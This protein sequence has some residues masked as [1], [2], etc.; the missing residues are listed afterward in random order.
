MT[1]SS[2]DLQISSL[3]LALV[4]VLGIGARA[5]Y[6]Y[7]PFDYR[8]INNWRQSDYL[9]ITRNFHR[10]GMNIFYPRVD[11]RGDTPGYVEMELPVLP[12]LGAW[13]YHFCGPHVQLLRALAATFD[14]GSLILFC[15]LA[16]DLLPA[17]GALFAVAAFA[18]NPMLIPLATSLQPEPVMQFFS[19]ASMLLLWRW[20]E[21]GAFST[22]L[23]ASVVLALAILG[24][25]PAICLGFVFAYAVLRKLRLAALSDFRVYVAALVAVGPPLA[26]Y[27][28][29]YRFWA[30]YGN[31]LGLSSEYH[32]LG[33]DL[34]VPPRFLVGILRTETFYIFTPLGW[35]LALSALRLPWSKVERLFAWYGTVC[36]FYVVAGRAT[37]E[38]WAEYYHVLSIAP[39]CLLMGAGVAAWWR[40]DGEAARA[41]WQQWTG[42]LLAA[43]T[44]VACVCVAVYTHDRGTEEYLSMYTCALEFAQRVPPSERIVVRGG[45]SSDGRG[46]AIAHNEPMMF[47][48][49]DRKGFNYANE[50]L[51]IETLDAI[52]A[53]G[54][55]Y[56]VVG[57]EELKQDDLERAA[58]ARYRRIAA[59]RSLYYLYD[60]R[61]N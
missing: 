56:W 4:M 47:A 13:L 17:S 24:K 9:Q 11:W 6:V 7:R 29:G 16:R 55:R 57:R 50:D 39:A 46:H 49:M 19:L 21:R 8:I 2:N 27:L 31:S 60:L 22:L 33:V 32:F 34:L 59:C 36:V 10:E 3:V 28:W 53:R 15:F 41:R 18:V 30:F 5:A 35:V 25:L 14:V 45:I 58:N 23:A 20:S 44:L 40:A 26:W 12:W 51:R 61:P 38:R 42:A 43:G 37:G 52:A 54:G 1:R 48:W